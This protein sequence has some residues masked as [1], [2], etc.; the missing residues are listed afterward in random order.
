MA[1]SRVNPGGAA[2]DAESHHSGSSLPFLPLDKQQNMSH[3]HSSGH[4]ISNTIS[5]SNTNSDGNNNTSSSRDYGHMDAS[6]D[7]EDAFG[8]S[9]DDNSKLK[10]RANQANIMPPAVMKTCRMPLILPKVDAKKL[11]LGC[12]GFIFVM[13]IWDAFFTPP[14]Q[15]LLQPDFS[16]RF[17]RWVQLHP[18]KGMFAI[19]VVIAVA[20]VSMVPIGTPLTLGCGFIYRG[21]YGWRL[22]LFVS[23]AIAMLGSTMGAIVCFLLGRYL[24]REQVR[25]WV[26]N[27]PI[28]DAID[29]GENPWVLQVVSIM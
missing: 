28:F 26:R 4:N 24:M 3:A 13:I 22:G 11:L 9:G 12:M 10:R 25:K 16:D 21:V 19:L 1:R 14:E 18:A 15:R 27:Y 2:G 17:L 6:F 20:V 29:T 8:N 7:A 23:T 5:I